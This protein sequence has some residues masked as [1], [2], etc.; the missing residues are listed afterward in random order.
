MEYRLLGD[1]GLKVS[2]LSF[3]N[4]TFGGESFFKGAG[5]TQLEEAKGFTDACIDAGVNLFDTAD[6]YSTGKAEEILGK[7]LGKKRDKVLIA[8]KCHFRMGDDVNDVGQ[9]R[10]HIVRACEASLKRLGTDYIDIYQVHNF[11]SLTSLEQTM[12]ALDDLVRAGK[13]RYIG[14]SNLPA[15]AIMKSL[16]I[17]DKRSLEKFVSLQSY[18]SLVARELEYEFVPLC[19]NE[20]MGILVWGPL[21]GGFLSGKY[22]RGKANDPNSRR[23]QWGDYGTFDQEQGFAIVDVLLSIAKERNVSASQVALNYLLHKKGVTSLIL[24]A[25]KMEQLK[26]NLATV[27]WK[28]SDGEMKR[29]NEA[30]DVPAPYPYWHHRQFNTERMP[31]SEGVNGEPA[32]E[33]VSPGSKK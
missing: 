3:G 20:G 24:G 5:D 7:A 15:W 19:V 4:M 28:L 1:S 13:V 26:D 29:L 21:A 30:S 27:N 2:A 33:L 22:Q 25:R 16:S 31:L 17:S 32:R 6:V 11:D 9:S 14:C 8:T 10:H 12:R 18:Y 23:A